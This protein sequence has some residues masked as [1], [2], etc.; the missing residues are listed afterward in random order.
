MSAPNPPDDAARAAA[1]NN[2][3]Q[4]RRTLL[5]WIADML[6]GGEDSGPGRSVLRLLAF[7]W[8]MVGFGLA[9]L[10]VPAIAQAAIG[11]Y[12]QAFTIV[13]VGLFLAGA[14]T[15]FGSMLGFLFG[16]PKASLNPPPD[17]LQRFGD[18][19]SYVPNTNLETISDWLTKVIVGVGLVQVR[20]LIGWVDSVGQVAGIA[21]G[22]TEVMRVVATS[23]LVHNVLMGFFQG[24]LVAYLYLPKVFAA[25]RRSAQSTPI[26]PPQ[27]TSG[28]GDTGDP[29][30][31]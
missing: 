16:V 27:P 17:G 18:E 11:N 29:L 20:E 7:V 6:F 3:Q 24:F 23:L 14:A 22:G 4:P 19:P 15:A 13:G 25:A 9:S 12:G 8:G 10:L 26:R 1:L 21:M 2:T 28:I 5:E 31:P 30:R